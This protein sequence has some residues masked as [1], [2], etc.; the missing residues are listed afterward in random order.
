MGLQQRAHKP[1]K[2]YPSPIN[3]D[4]SA[5]QPQLWICGAAASADADALA[6]EAAG[7]VAAAADP[8]TNH[9]YLQ[10]THPNL[11]GARVT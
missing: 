5:P 10:R 2:P 6:G 11:T 4:S 3:S 8:R 7:L 9:D 1:L